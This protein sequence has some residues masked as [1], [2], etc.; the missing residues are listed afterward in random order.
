MKTKRYVFYAA[1]YA[2]LLAAVLTGCKNPAAPS[3]DEE[4]PENTVEIGS[5]N[6]ELSG[7]GENN[8]IF[9]DRE[10]SVLT[11]RVTGEGWTGLTWSVD[12]QSKGTGETL[13]IRAADYSEAR[14]I[15]ALTGAREGIPYST[16]IP[17][18]VTRERTGDIVWTQTAGDSSLTTFD[19]S[20]WTGDGSPTETWRLNVLEQS[21]VYFAVRKSPQA[22]IE[23]RNEEGATVAKAAA[24]D[25]VDGSTANA[26]LDL[27][28]VTLD[29]DAVFGEG[30][31]RFTLVTSEEG[32]TDKTVN[33]TVAV[34]PNLT[35]IA[36]FHRTNGG[37]ARITSDNAADHANALYATHKSGTFPDW[38]L[39]FAYV[40]NL[41]TALK[42]LDNYAQGGTSETWAEYL[43]RVEAD[44]A[45]PKTL[46]SC[47]ISA[48]PSQVGMEYIRIRIRGYGEERKITHDWSTHNGS[49]N[50]GGYSMSAN[51]AFLSIGSPST[52]SPYVL[53]HL[54]IRL[55]K[56]ITIDAGSGTNPYFP[57]R[58]K[59][60]LIASMV[61]ISEGNT[62]V[63]EAGSKLT[64]YSY[65][66]A[67]GPL[68]QMTA[69]T[70][71]GGV[72]EL[73]DGEISNILGHGNIVFCYDGSSSGGAYHTGT[74]IYYNGVFSG[75]TGNEI[76]VGSYHN[77][78]LY[79][80]T[81]DRFKQP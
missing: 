38:G 41:S 36:V 51:D 18:T 3:P 60:P 57:N 12:G 69:V 52:D 32:K 13:T 42:W 26:G 61:N 22:R 21:V 47:R 79:D 73:R 6:P 8:V 14:H 48:S 28:T 20:A 16:T 76:A 37:L 7:G 62:L 59:P 30:E 45:M 49:V 63:M 78:T 35:G 81:D 53:N 54:E 17:V 74:F 72:F 80:V 9:K 33:V 15:V 23:V 67:Q 25:T 1:F 43:V 27:F 55:E 77:P 4:T 24:G 10:P 29:R 70:L 71:R 68:F 46:I 65:T 5:G 75:N 44:E 40:Q 19:L 11:L 2:A 56:N 34:Q 31:C 50:K 66:V 58:S 39:D 64:N